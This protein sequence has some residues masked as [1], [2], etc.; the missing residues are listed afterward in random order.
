[1]LTLISSTT[2]SL[3]A[4]LLA[5][6]PAQSECGLVNATGYCGTLFGM[7]REEAM[8]SSKIGLAADISELDEDEQ[9]CYYLEPPS[10]SFGFMMVEGIVRRLDVFDGGI[11]TDIGA[12][13]GMSKEKVLALYPEASLSPNFYTGDDDII[14][15]LE[16]GNK[17]IFETDSTDTAID[18][19]RVGES[20]AIDYVEGCL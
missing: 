14:I 16:N 8:A 17:L 10:Q 18:L 20:P 5:S 4:M 12:E 3:L 9:A 11:P 19:Y 13:I 2:V 15:T 1:M 6:D 7:T